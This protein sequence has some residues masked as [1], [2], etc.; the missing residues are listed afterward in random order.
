M[1]PAA[2]QEQRRATL[3]RLLFALSLASG[4]AALMLAATGGFTVR[5]YGI[6]I[7]AHGSL[8][9][10][11]LALL[12]AALSLRCLPHARQAQIVARGEDLLFRWLPA[13]ALVASAAILA[14]GVTL[15]TR[16]A[17]GSDGYGYVSEA[18]LWLAGDLHVHQD[19]V[20]DVPWP[21]AEWTFAPLG[22]RPADGHTLVPTYPPG[23]PLLMA[24]LTTAFGRCG[25]Y[26]LN[27]ICGA[28]LVL[29]AY[30]LG[31]RV[32][33][34]VTGAMAA[35]SVASSPTVLFMS[36][37]PMS[38][39]PAAAFWTLSLLLA[40]G[41]TWRAAAAAGVATGV[42]VA[43]R[44]NLAPLACFPLLMLAWPLRRSPRQALWRGLTFGAACLPFVLFITWL[45]S[46]LYGSPLQSGYGEAS[47]IFDSR[48][49]LANLVRYPRW[50]WETQG[51]LPFLFPLAALIPGRPGE[52]PRWLRCVL[53]GFVAAVWACY[54]WYE[55][56]DAWWYLRFV[57]PA[58][59]VMFVLA[60]DAVWRGAQ[61]F[62]RRVRIVTAVVFV[63]VMMDYGLTQARA[64]AAFGIGVGEQ[65]YADVGRYVAHELPDNAVVFTMQHSGSVRYYSQ[66]RTIQW[67][68][69][70]P[71]WL[72]RAIDYLR[73]AGFEPYFV[74]EA[75]EVPRFREHFGSQQS[76]AVLD[77]PALAAHSRGVYIY[78]TRSGDQHATPRAIPHTAGC[79]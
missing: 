66:R 48:N 61:R 76:V 50:L 56:F 74:L 70:A 16:A 45:N 60:A 26:L 9:P 25:P 49:T 38:D 42:A 4:A 64:R 7:S 59:P 63:G 14:L 34:R 62:G 24:L 67:Q 55:P 78:A 33:G 40:C 39:V 72:D 29:L 71:E 47:S 6:R 32:S 23:A 2:R 52:P 37:W 65:K 73:G 57:L 79:E 22:Y 68:W 19:F 15:G 17:G 54:L 1:M 31:V 21:N 18:Q 53:V 75:W 3:A 11:L 5:P 58:F 12:L 20:A 46:D 10:M 43:I 51:P 27:P 44:P 36:M 30:A 41:R 69:L 28:L 8:R 35:L 13:V 77:R